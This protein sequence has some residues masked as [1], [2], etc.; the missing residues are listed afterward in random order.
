MGWET[1]FL[2]QT[3]FYSNKSILLVLFVG[4]NGSFHSRFHP[5]P[6]QGWNLQEAVDLGSSPCTGVSGILSG[7][8]KFCGFPLYLSISSI[9]SW[10]VSM[11]LIFQSTI[12]DKVWMIL[13]I[14]TQR[15]NQKRDT[16]RTD[17]SIEVSRLTLRIIS[18]DFHNAKWHTSL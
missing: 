8:G 17:I 3:K 9:D 4:I 2:N 10:S 18:I 6:A 12:C 5:P 11:V 13:P 16:S 15:V 7:L 14:V 1:Y